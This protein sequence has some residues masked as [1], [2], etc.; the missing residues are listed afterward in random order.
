MWK[1][2]E[3]AAFPAQMA[4]ESRDFEFVEEQKLS[5]ECSDG[6]YARHS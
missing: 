1:T 3:T 4:R 2:S 5:M 6:G